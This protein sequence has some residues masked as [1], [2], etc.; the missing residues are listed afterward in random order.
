MKFLNG[1][2]MVGFRNDKRLKNEQILSENEFPL[3]NI[4]YDKNHTYTVVDLSNNNDKGR[5]VKALSDFIL[6]KYEEKILK[7]IIQKNYPEIPK[8]NVHEII[9]LNKTTDKTER[10]S[11]VENILKRYFKENDCA[12][13]EGIVNFRL[14]D[15]KAI[16]GGVAGELVDVYYLNREYEDF[17]ELIR[18]FLSI[19]EERAELVYVVV[20]NDRMYDVLDENGKNITKEIIQDL[21]PESELKNVSYDDLL[22][23]MMISVAPK[24]IVVKNQENI[25]NKQL[26]ITLEKAFL[27][28]SY[29]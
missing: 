10:K 14:N 11:V 20:N 8:T 22:I 19:Q 5:Y 25:K 29:V 18:F 4:F 17:I 2:I 9:K 28:V 1:Q 21:V 23:S 27:N 6:D 24:K 7:Q 13:V 12:N 3:K 16:L 26:F 15:Y